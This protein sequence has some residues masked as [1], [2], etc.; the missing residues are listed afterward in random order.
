MGFKS[1]HFYTHFWASYL[2][3]HCGYRQYD[4][5]LSLPWE[6]QSAVEKSKSQNNCNMR[7]MRILADT[8]LNYSL[9]MLIQTI[10]SLFKKFEG[11]FFP[12]IKW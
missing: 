2:C 7:N 5:P 8:T 6:A 3:T 12:I 10:D 9:C 4:M 1:K 11:F